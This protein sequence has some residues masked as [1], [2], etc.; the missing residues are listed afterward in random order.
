MEE[1]VWGD[2]TQYAQRYEKRI[3]CKQ[4]KAIA[5]TFANVGTAGTQSN[6]SK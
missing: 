6:W 2:E 5:D 4:A 1:P 3:I